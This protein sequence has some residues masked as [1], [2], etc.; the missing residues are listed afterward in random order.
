MPDEKDTPYDLDELI[1]LQRAANAE[2]EKLN[3]LAGEY[4]RPT[5]AWTE[6]QHAAW[7][8]QWNAWGDAVQKIFTARENHP[9]AEAMGRVKLEMAVKKAARSEA[10]T[11]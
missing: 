7:K 10:P 11:S 6:E 4:G 2:Q 8:T 5:S 1:A 3:A 9:A